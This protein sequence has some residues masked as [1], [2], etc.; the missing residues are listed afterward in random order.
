MEEVCVGFACVHMKHYDEGFE[1]LTLTKLHNYC[2]EHT[3]ASVIY[4]HSKGSFHNRPNNTNNHWRRHMTMAVTSPACIHGI[5]NTT[6]NVCGLYFFPMWNM[7]FAGNFFTTKCSYVQKL[8]PPTN[9]SKVMTAIVGDLLNASSRLSS[10]N[11][12]YNLYN[13]KWDGFM[14]ADRYAA[15]LW[16]VSHPDVVPC[17]MSAVNDFLHWQ[18]G[19]DSVDNEL[20]W[21]LAP[22]YSLWDGQWLFM[23]YD[24]R[25]IL[26]RDRKS[27]MHEYVLLAG[28]LYTW[29]TIYH[30]LPPDDSWVWEWYPDGSDWKRIKDIPWQA[31]D[32]VDLIS[33]TRTVAFELS[34]ES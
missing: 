21:S 3:E 20:K 33:Y 1:D 18:R 23:E 27:R 2:H 10:L 16:S 12:Q 24:K 14:G 19:H 8:L 25:E 7:M 29:L 28:K 26:A 22:R 9:Y 34:N 32:P 17:D 5:H 11:L 13:M 30:E 4:L 31:Q 15:E 6:C